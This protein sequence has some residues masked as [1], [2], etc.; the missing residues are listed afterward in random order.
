MKIKGVDVSQWQGGI[1]WDSAKADG[2]KF[3]IVRL[4]YRN[5]LDTYAPTNIEELR[6]LGIHTEV[7]WFLY[8]NG[9]T[10]KENAQATAKYL[11][12]TKLPKTTRVW[13]DLE[14]DSWTKAGETA[15]KKRCSDI[16]REY[17][18]E[19]ARLG[20]NR[21]GIYTNEDYARNYI[22]WSRFEGL[23]VWFANYEGE[24]S[25]PYL[26]HQATS[27]ARVAGFVGDVDIDYAD[28]EALGITEEEEQAMGITAKQILDTA[29]SWLGY[30]EASGKHW[31]I[32]NGVYNK[33]IR[34][35]PTEGRGYCLSRDDA[36]CDCF[37]SS[38]FIKNG[39]VDAI[40]AVECGCPNH[41]QKLREAGLWKGLTKPQP[42]DIIFF[43]WQN[44]RNEWGSDHVGIVETV[45]GDTVITI[46]GNRNNSVGRRTL[47]WNAPE[48][49]GYARPRYTKQEAT[50]TPQ[51][52]AGD[53]G[54][55][56]TKS[57]APLRSE[58]LYDAVVECKNKIQVYTGPG[59]KNPRCKTFGPFE[60]GHRL[61][62]IDEMK[63]GWL[64]IRDTETDKRGF[65]SGK[66]VLRISPQNTTGGLSKA[67]RAVG[68]VTADDLN[69]RA[70][71]GTE[72]PTTSFSPLAKGTKVTVCDTIQAAD[73]S[74]WHYI[75]YNGKFGFVSAKYITTQFDG[76]YF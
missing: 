15:T 67:M 4:G 24:P 74:D 53:P 9:A 33:Y 19:L 54:E 3:A 12:A 50:Q 36:W 68:T 60:D 16:M 13:C 30:D 44:G 55:W 42:G 76:S 11:D 56:Q 26:I 69:V 58:K 31:Q 65:V 48:V 14:Y 41:I 45:N 32:V 17:I 21:V 71:A 5:R 28:S 34:Q 43:D 10:I 18:D 37:V 47:A 7:Y 46:E 38:L 6:R 1:N 25:C 64:F 49:V 40:G 51:E 57:G 59:T 8:W 62:V 35:H 70:W 61:E 29:R 20:I 27:K 39:A 22:D 66:H 73:G 75:K 2:I 23:P 52:T 63:N 72:H